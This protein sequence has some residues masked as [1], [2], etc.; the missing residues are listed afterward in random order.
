VSDLPD[1]EITVAFKHLKVPLIDGSSPK[2]AMKQIKQI[3]TGWDI[4]GKQRAESLLE[5]EK[6]IVCKLVSDW[7]Q[8]Y[9]NMQKKIPIVLFSTHPEW[10]IGTRFDNG[11]M[12]CTFIERLHDT[13]FGYYVIVYDEHNNILHYNPKK[14]RWEPKK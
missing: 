6:I 13:L 4:I 5:M 1:N 14:Y 7:V 12:E 11:L 9:A 2:E 8:P 3:M 10:K